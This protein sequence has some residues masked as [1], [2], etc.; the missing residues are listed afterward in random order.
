MNRIAQRTIVLVWAILAVALLLFPPWKGDT[1]LVRASKGFHF[2]LTQEED[3]GAGH[4][5]VDTPLLAVAQAVL[6]AVAGTA[7]YTFRDR[8][9]R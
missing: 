9:S 8:L 4:S 3:I 7:V 1:G 6:A 2:I 5:F